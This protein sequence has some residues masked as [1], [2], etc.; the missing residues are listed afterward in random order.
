MA[1]IYFTKTHCWARRED[2][3]DV[4]VGIT[5]YG[6]EQMSMLTFVEVL[7]GVGEQV[8]ADDEI[9]TLESANATNEVYCPVTGTVTA[10]NEELG[11]QPELVNRDPFGQGWLLK[12][13][14]ENESELEGLLDADG[15]EA[16]LPSED[17]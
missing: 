7:P 3:G 15:Y 12:V 11:D 6:Q 17:D 2:N 1:E 14:P 9:A 5:D 10:V 16:I 8:E 13:R 4:T